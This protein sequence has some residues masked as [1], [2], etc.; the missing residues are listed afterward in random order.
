MAA[1]VTAAAQVGKSA[2]ALP[3]VQAEFDLSLSTAAWFV[4]I[5]SLIGAIT[6][7]VLGWVGQAIG[8]RR[9]IQAG[10]LAI[11]LM[12]I[13]GLA[14][15][16]TA[17]LLVTRV[18]EGLG[19]ALV[20]LAAPGLLTSITEP[21]HRRLVVGAWGA[22]MPI[23]AGL[24]TL[25]VPLAIPHIG[26]RGAWGVGAFLA[27]CALVAVN[28]SIP[29]SPASRMPR[30]GPLRSTV[31]SPGVMCLAAVFGLYAAQYLAVLGLLPTMLV[32]DG[33][34]S[35]TMA[36][37]VTGIAFVANAPGNIAGALLQHRGIARHRLIIGGSACMAVSA[38][39]LYDTGLPLALRVAAAV[40]FSVTAGVV[41][42]AAFAGVATMTANTDS[43]GAG[44]GV[45]MQGSSIG[46]L[47]GPPL[48]VAATAVTASRLAAPV[49]LCSLAGLAIVGGLLYR[50]LEVRVAASR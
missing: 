20:V 27:L 48:V 28:R 16:G 42:S 6:G 33:A 12:N 50:R 3:V 38:W 40:T 34:M 11:L 21:A 18:G 17:L 32:R 14:S 24:A 37:V 41:P 1:G 15:P 30:A 25:L 4:S 23:G 13:A 2:A 9:Q 26:W 43:V 5:I 7:A 45:L 36:G 8:F 31:R 10:L 39:I 44:M 19:F 22:Y 49:A 46:Q 35:L 47:I 29:A